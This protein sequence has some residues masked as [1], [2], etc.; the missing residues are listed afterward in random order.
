MR[1]WLNAACALLISVA[2]CAP[3][4]GSLAESP[5]PAAVPFER[6]VLSNNLTLI[7]HEDHDE[8]IVHVR[9]FYHV[10]EKDAGRNQTGYAHLFD[11]VPFV[12]GGR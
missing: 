2:G 11:S 1:C 4:A 9:M 7:V 3:A 8:P 5:A 10:G 6:F 12:V